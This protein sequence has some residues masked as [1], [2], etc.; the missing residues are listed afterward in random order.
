MLSLINNRKEKVDGLII[1]DMVCGTVGRPYPKIV[2]NLEW[3]F[4]AHQTAEA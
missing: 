1:W 2:V 3:R 4:S